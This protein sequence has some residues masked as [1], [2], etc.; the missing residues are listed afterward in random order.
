MRIPGV[1]DPQTFTGLKVESLQVALHFHPTSAWED[2]LF[3]LN[4][5]SFQTDGYK[6][7]LSWY[8]RLGMVLIF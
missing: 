8:N 6:N 4:G 5:A 1:L 3:K 7:F 2:R